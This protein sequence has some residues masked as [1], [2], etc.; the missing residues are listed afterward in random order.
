MSDTKPVFTKLP[1]E[2]FGIANVS[3]TA[4]TEAV[5]F[6]ESSHNQETSSVEDL[7]ADLLSSFLL[8]KLKLLKLDGSEWLFRRNDG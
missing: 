1:F 6:K 2:P 5:G 3:V 7:E 4:E 8:S